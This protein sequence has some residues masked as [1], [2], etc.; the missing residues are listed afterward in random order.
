MVLV[1][2]VL[3]QWLEMQTLK[4]WVMGS[5]R[6]TFKIFLTFLILFSQ[7]ELSYRLGKVRIGY[8]FFKFSRDLSFPLLKIPAA[9]FFYFIYSR[10]QLN[11]YFFKNEKNVLI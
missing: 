7:N 1:E 2:V 3:V 6:N 4:G 9:D 8:F 11:E 5:T 10:G